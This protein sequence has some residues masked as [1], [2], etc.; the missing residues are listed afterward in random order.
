MLTNVALPAGDTLSYSLTLLNSGN[1]KLRALDVGIAGSLAN[2]SIGA[3][4]CTVGS[5]AW[6]SDGDLTV[7]QQLV[8]STS[9]TLS[10]ETVEA[11]GLSPVAVVKAINM[12]QTDLDLPSFTVINRP[13]LS[14]TVDSASC[15][16]PNKA[17]MRAWVMLML[18]Q[19]LNSMDIS[20]LAYLINT[21]SSNSSNSCTDICEWLAVASRRTY[22]HTTLTLHLLAHN[23]TTANQHFHYTLAATQASLSTALL[24]CLTVAMCASSTSPSVMQSAAACQGTCCC[25]TATSLAPSAGPATRKTLKLAALAGQQQQQLARWVPT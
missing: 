9:F 18:L 16:V 6:L 17:G 1:V 19:I 25:R 4:T 23:L 12:T 8:C 20:R 22:M 5:E 2:A 15:S 13:S 10:Q 3:M 7:G 14:A 24:S 21:P 11:G